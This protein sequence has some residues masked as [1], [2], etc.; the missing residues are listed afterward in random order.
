[1]N[2]TAQSQPGRLHWGAILLA[3]LVLCSVVLTAC[4][5]PLDVGPDVAED[6]AP[7]SSSMPSRHT[8]PVYYIGA[9]ANDELLYREF[10]SASSSADPIADAVSAM[11]RLRPRDSTYKNF[12]T[13]ASSVTTSLQ[14]QSITVDIS[15]D[16]FDTKLKLTD[17]QAQQSIQQLIYTATA[18]ASQF[19]L[20]DGITSVAVLVDGMPSYRAWDSIELG[21]PEGRSTAARSPIWLIDPAEGGRFSSPKVTIAGSACSDNGRIGWEVRSGNGDVI[22]AGTL[23]VSTDVNNPASFEFTVDLKPGAYTVAVYGVPKGEDLSSSASRREY[24]DRKSLTVT[25]DA[26][27]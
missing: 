9:E 3:A 12:W 8:V 17:R 10:R 5:G 6:A 15:S 11:T 14:N 2:S 4:T 23:P 20:A 19:Q 18:A 13:P 16:A 21:R 24:I 1:M 27:R 7:Q 26:L 25:G 22:E